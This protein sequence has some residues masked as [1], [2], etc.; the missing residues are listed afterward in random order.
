MKIGENGEPVAKG[1]RNVAWVLALQVELSGYDVDL[2]LRPRDGADFRRVRCFNLQTGSPATKYAALANGYH[3][4][5]DTNEELEESTLNPF[6]F[7]H[8]MFE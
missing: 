1:K 2:K 4:I 7:F 6:C 3:H 8:I 5:L